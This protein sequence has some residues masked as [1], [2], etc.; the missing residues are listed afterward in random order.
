LRETREKGA[1]SPPKPFQCRRKKK[2]T[3]KKKKE[4]ENNIELIPY[5]FFPLEKD[6]STLLLGSCLV[7]HLAV[8]LANKVKE[9]LIDVDLLAGGSLEEGNVAPRVGKLATLLLAN[10]TVILEIALVADE[11]HGHLFS[12][13]CEKLNH[14]LF[15]STGTLS[16]SLTRRICSRRSP[17]SWKVEV[18]VIE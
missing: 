8:D 7:G 10:S 15:H 9:D 1:F 11:H 4:G 2:Q 12:K 16:V 5:F 13:T 3:Y 18:E 6:A 14:V 17:R